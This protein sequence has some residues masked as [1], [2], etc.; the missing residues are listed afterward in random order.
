MNNTIKQENKKLSNLLEEIRNFKISSNSGKSY[1]NKAMENI[2]EA[3]EENWSLL[4]I[5][6]KEGLK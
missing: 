3:I 4:E 2:Q 6:T 5:K 1:L